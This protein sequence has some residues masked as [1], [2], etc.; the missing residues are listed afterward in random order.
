MRNRL[1]LLKLL[2]KS[3]WS[4]IRISNTLVFF[5]LSTLKSFH[6]SSF[7]SFLT[8]LWS[9]FL[10]FDLLHFY[11]HK[12]IVVCPLLI[13]KIIIK[14]TPLFTVSKGFRPLTYLKIVTLSS[15]KRWE[16]YNCKVELKQLPIIADPWVTP[17]CNW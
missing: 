8:E 16:N 15:G 12:P 9:S 10:R 4:I 17:P 13:K 5:L 7:P 11:V 6:F 1:Q 2:Y 3:V 14:T